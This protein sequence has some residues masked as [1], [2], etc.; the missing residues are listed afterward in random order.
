MVKIDLGPQ[1][2]PLDVMRIGIVCDPFAC[3]LYVEAVGRNPQ[4]QVGISPLK[5]CSPRIIPAEKEMAA[6]FDEIQ[7][8]PEPT[9]DGNIDDRHGSACAT[10]AVRVE[11][12]VNEQVLRLTEVGLEFAVRVVCNAAIFLQHLQQ[13]PAA[14][15]PQRV[16]V[17]EFGLRLKHARIE[18]VQMSA[19][20][21][22]NPF[23]PI[24][25][26]PPHLFNI[27]VFRA[28][29]FSSRHQIQ[30]GDVEIVP[31]TQCESGELFEHGKR[32]DHEIA[33]RES[34]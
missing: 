28:G 27:G 20:L 31:G 17:A 6:G 34:A 10:F 32:I 18:A 14:E 3:S 2:R 1:L 13:V 9:T 8:K 33:P 22:T 24:I 11:D 29:K 30:V 26:T 4:V 25:E 5:L 16:A 21:K 23:R 19:N 7:R 15:P 12:A